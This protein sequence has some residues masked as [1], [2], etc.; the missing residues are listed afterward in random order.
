MTVEIERAIIQHSVRD[1]IQILENERVQPDLVEQITVA[2]IMNRVSLAHLSIERAMK[3]LITR[4]GGPLTKDH[5]LGDRLRELIQ[6]EPES[7]DFLADAFQVAVR[8]YRFNPNVDHAGHLRSLESYLDIAGSDKA[9]QDLRYWELGQSPDEVLLRQ[10]NLALHLELLHATEEVLRGRPPIDTVATRVERAV[11]QAMF[12]PTDLAYAPGTPK[13]DSVRFYMKWRRG[14]ASWSDA[15]ADAARQQF[16]IGDGFASGVVAKAHQMLL[17]SV[18]PAVSYFAETLDVLPKQRRD[19]I[20]PVEWIGTA[21]QQRGVVNTP[22]GVA[23][24]EIE[25]RWDGF[26]HVVPFQR[27]MEAIPARAMSQTDARCYLAALFSR[28]AEITV[29]GEQR[30]HQIVASEETLMAWMEVR[31]GY[32]DAPLNDDGTPFREVV[33]WDAN[34]GLKSDDRVNIRVRSSL[35]PRLVHVLTGVV[36][37]VERHAVYV[38]GAYSDEVDE[39]DPE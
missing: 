19:V 32:T 3:F 2:R 28:V 35:D 16:M 30:C 36:A 38:L 25:R 21:P 24:G 39:P 22:S 33:F 31:V 23:L 9:F 20:P 15:L 14:F 37:R 17:Q 11:Q 18:D 13:E 6:N 4:A 8:H 34:H 5:H 1:V 10:L 12:S 7:A 29:N 27:G 26:W